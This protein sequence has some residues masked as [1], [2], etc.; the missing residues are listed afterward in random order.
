[1]V[2]P[3]S[4][5]TAS[6]LKSPPVLAE[7]WEPE[8]DDMDDNDYFDE[9]DSPSLISTDK[10][11][12][13]D[14]D[15]SPKNAPS[16]FPRSDLPEEREIVDER[17]D[18]EEPR[19]HRRDAA[20]EV[21]RFD[22]KF[23]VE[24]RTPPTQD[25][26]S[27]IKAALPEPLEVFGEIGQNGN[28]QLD[29]MERAEDLKKEKKLDDLLTKV[30]LQMMEIKRDTLTTDADVMKKMSL[31]MSAIT[32]LA[33]QSK[34]ESTNG[35]ATMR[36][37]MDSKVE[38]KAIKR[39]TPLEVENSSHLFSGA[40]IQMGLFAIAE[41][42]EDGSDEEE[43]R[44]SQAV[45]RWVGNDER[46][47][48]SIRNKLG[49]LA[50]GTVL[51]EHVKTYYVQAMVGD[52][53]EA[54]KAFKAFDYED[55]FNGT[56]EHMH[57]SMDRFTNILSHLSKSRQGDPEEW[58]EFL[59][60][61]LPDELATEYDRYMRKLTTREVRKATMDITTFALYLGKAMT[62][63]NARKPKTKKV[64]E[65]L[66]MSA[67]QKRGGLVLQEVASTIEGHRRLI[68]PTTKVE[69]NV[70]PRCSLRKCPK[71]ND[72]NACCDVCDEISPERAAAITKI[73]A[74]KDKIDDKRIR[75]NKSPINYTIKSST[76]QLPRY[77]DEMLAK[78]DELAGPDFPQGSGG[79]W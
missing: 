75:F 59:S 67:H 18:D 73:F 65:T 9:L 2:A 77:V 3:E 44:L 61:E 39:A 74:Y 43:K 69:F 54:E 8:I 1:M 38:I 48:S 23:D 35:T 56:E 7:R 53:A 49:L 40:L 58:V 21:F 5:P 47:V 28:L 79:G 63:L 29:S 36:A 26:Q 45:M 31:M 30:S 50:K 70:C 6:R 57:D 62:K 32:V 25:N 19:D 17:Q 14:F 10:K 12:A 68:D 64:E 16:I 37:M 78:I 42:D 41:G 76:H 72:P 22:D 24:S 66:S 52:A 46:I 60:E 51:F 55:M 4:D 11:Y 27:E 33:K 15:M 34:P 13:G 20:H 71:A